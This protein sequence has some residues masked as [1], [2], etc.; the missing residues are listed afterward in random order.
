MKTETPDYV[1]VDVEGR[2]AFFAERGEE[3]EHSEGYYHVQELDTNQSDER[4]HYCIFE[5]NI[6]ELDWDE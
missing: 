5:D 2:V 1:I 6:H 4:N 3:S